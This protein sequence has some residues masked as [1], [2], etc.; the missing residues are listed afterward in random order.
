MSKTD[1]LSIKK[2]GGESMREREL[3]CP[4]GVSRN[5][6]DFSRQPN[7]PSAG[8]GACVQINTLPPVAACESIHTGGKHVGRHNETHKQNTHTNKQDSRFKTAK[9]PTRKGKLKP[10]RLPMSLSLRHKHWLFLTRDI[11]KSIFLS[12]T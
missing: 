10:I 1:R 5:R 11:Q 12:N 4:Q 8:S 3:N 6:G 2:V 9:T 7:G